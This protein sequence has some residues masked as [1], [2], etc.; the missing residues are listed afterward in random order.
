MAG[1]VLRLRMRAIG[2][3]FVNPAGLGVL[4]TF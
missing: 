3:T 1:G 2:L 4:S